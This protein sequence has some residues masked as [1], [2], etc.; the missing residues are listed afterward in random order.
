MPPLAHMAVSLPMLMIHMML[1]SRHRSTI[2]TYGMASSQKQNTRS[3]KNKMIIGNIYKPPKDNNNCGNVNGFINELEPILS[4]LGNTNSE[5][6]ICG[7]YNINLLKINSEQHFSYFFDT[8]LTHSFFLNITFRTRVN[9][10]CGATLIDNILLLSDPN[11]NYDILHNHISKMK[12]KHLPHTFKFEKYHKHKN[13]KW[14]SFRII[15]SIKTRDAMYLKF[16]RCNQHH[17]KYNTLKNNLL[18]F[19]C[20]LKKTIREAKIQYY[21]K[22]FS[23]YKSDIKKI[24]VVNPTRK[25]NHQTKS[26]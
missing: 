10:S 17:D 15:R 12:E 21:D 23:Q 25:E 8:M 13:N 1:K 19:N 18:V 9:N 2:P 7:D 16:K 11:M 26:S 3:W 4:D 22:L 24:L 6:L 14:I 5:V 20:I